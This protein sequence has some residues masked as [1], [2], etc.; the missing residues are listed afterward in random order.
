MSKTMHRLLAAA[1]LP[2]ASLTLSAQVASPPQPQESIKS[3]VRKNIAPV[4]SEI[5]KVKLPKAVERKLKN[6]LPVLVLENHRVPSISIMLVV[7]A[8][9]LSDP[10][11]R[12]GLADCVADMLTTGAGKRNAR[13]I[14]ERISDLGA[15]LQIAAPHASRFTTLNASTLTENLDPLLELVSD[16]LLR[17]AFSEDELK[18]WKTQQTGQLQQMRS[19][20]PYLANERLYQVLYPGDAREHFAQTVQTIQQITREDV[21]GFHKSFYKPGNSL[22]I[23]TGDTTPAAFTEKLEKYLGGW[24]SGMAKEPSLPLPGPA[25]ERRIV[26]VDRPGSVQTQLMLANHAIERKNPD[27]IA[28]QVMNRVL[29]QGPASRLFLKIREEKGYTYGVGSGFIATNYLNHFMAQSSVRTE[30]TGPALEEFLSEFRGIREKP[31]PK[32]ELE[33]AK[34]AIVAGFALDL[35]GQATALNQALTVRTYGLPAD[36]W[37]TYPAKIMAVTAEDVERVAKKYV[38]VDNLQVIAVGDAS[39]IREVLAK[40]GAVEEYSADGSKVSR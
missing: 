33:E 5:L 18:K 28:V 26:L 11:N 32:Q 16:V 15:T 20:P 37:D 25:A 8:S 31:V 34:R 23:V 7:P 2:A 6:G 19:S 30:V 13:E 40:F 10:A 35:E 17:P 9:T 12:P 1:L 27:Y 39:K 36:Y 14:A 21:T 24:E 3:V 4:S 22:L 38:P 29:G